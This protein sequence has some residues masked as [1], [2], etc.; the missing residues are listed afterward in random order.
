MAELFEANRVPFAFHGTR[1]QFQ[2]AKTLFSS[3]G[4]D[5]G[6]ALLLRHLQAAGLPAGGVVL[7]M[8]CGSGVLGI[9]LAALDPSRRVVLVDRDALACATTTR[10]LELNDLPVTHHAVKGS[11]GYDDLDRQTL[12]AGVRREF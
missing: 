3:A 10:N 5:A 2:L 12:V 7:D 11:L 8:G 1:L 6:S 9:V 4:I